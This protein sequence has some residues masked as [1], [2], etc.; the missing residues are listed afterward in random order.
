MRKYGIENFSFEIIEECSKE[1]LLEREKFWITYYNSYYYGYNCT[2]GGDMSGLNVQG[3]NHPN[4]KLSEKDVFDIRTRYANHERKR[5][6]FVFYKFKINQTG[7]DKVWKGNTWPDV[8]MEVYTDENK[9]FHKYNTANLYDISKIPYDEIL[10]IKEYKSNYMKKE[11]VFLLFK[12][13][14]PIDKF[15]YIWD[16]V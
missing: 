14:I 15:N 4:S 2:F 11:E 3:E 10:K 1:Q 8:L 13:F 16:G 6:V 5:E 12:D 7:F 9:F